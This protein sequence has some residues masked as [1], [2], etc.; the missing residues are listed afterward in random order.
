MIPLVEE[1][2][3][4]GGSGGETDVGMERTANEYCVEL[5]EFE[6]K[7]QVNRRL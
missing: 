6:V 3:Q 2:T 7:M 5:V 1:V 4:E